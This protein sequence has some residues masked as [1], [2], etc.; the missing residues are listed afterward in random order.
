MSRAEIV[1]DKPVPVEE[2]PVLQG[3]FAPV[4]EELMV[5]DL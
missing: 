4:D 2:N 5:Q 1:D 3:N